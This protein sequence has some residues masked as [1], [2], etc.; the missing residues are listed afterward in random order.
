[1]C[2]LPMTCVGDISPMVPDDIFSPE[3]YVCTATGSCGYKGILD[4]WQTQYVRCVKS[5]ATC[6]VGAENTEVLVER[7]LV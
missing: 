1:M 7:G 5:S 6:G 2:F 4:A 3:V